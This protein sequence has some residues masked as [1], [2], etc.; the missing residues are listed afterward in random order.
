MRDA[1]AFGHLGEV[2]APRRCR[3]A[4]AGVDA[5]VE[6]HRGQICR[7]NVGCGDEAAGLYD[8]TAIAVDRDHA[9]F[10]KG[11][12]DTDGKGRHRPMLRP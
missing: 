12:R 8:E 1:G 11:E 5:V 7:A 2:R 9:A 10:G 6:H 3:F 4:H